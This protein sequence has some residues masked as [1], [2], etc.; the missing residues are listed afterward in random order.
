MFRLAT[1]FNQ[2]ISS[3]NT[4][5]VTNMGGMFI[6]GAAFNQPIGSWDTANVT[7]MASMFSGA[8]SFNQNI[9]SWDTANVTSMASMFRNASTFNQNIGGWD[10]S[11]V[12]TMLEMFDGATAFNQPI[13]GW[14]TNN[15]TS[16]GAM[17]R[18]TTSFNQNLTGWCVGGISSLPGGF[19][20]SSALLAENRPIWGTCPGFEV[21]VSIAYIGVAAGTDS[22]TLPA[23]Q[24]GD[25]IIAFA[26][27]NNTTVSITRPDGWSNITSSVGGT[28][29]DSRSVNTGYK[30]ATSSSET[31][32]TWTNATRVIFQ[33]YRNVTSVPTVVSSA[34]SSSTVVTYDTINTWPNLGWT[35]A[36]MGHN[37]TNNSAGTPTGLTARS[38][39]NSGARMLGADSNATTSG[40]TTQSINIG[41]TARVWGSVVLR[42]RNKIKKIGT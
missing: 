33:V 19:S 3:W 10:T 23:H 27:G 24:A 20:S 42:L 8:A 1:S 22:A 31:S 29:T 26:Y 41:G 39:T 28:S 13:G 5:N 6:S 15:V 9:G 4:T 36:F 14:D 16:M 12:T 30:I 25:Y 2:N 11:S 38:S 34:I 21:D 32:G 17:F 18:G 35:V 40:F 7:S 37:A